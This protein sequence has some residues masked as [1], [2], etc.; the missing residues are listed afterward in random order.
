MDINFICG[1]PRAGTTFL[2]NL[3][4]KHSRIGSVG[5]TLYFGR[6]FIESEND[7]YND[8]QINKIQ[9][10]LININYKNLKEDENK[11]FQENIVAEFKKI[12]R[13][14]ASPKVVFNAYAKAY[15]DVFEG[16]KIFFEKTPHHIQH[17]ERIRM[18]YP[19]AKF[20]ILMRD[21]Y[22]WML[23][24]K[25]QGSQVNKVIR[26]AFKSI[27]HP[28]ACALIWK[29][30]YNSIEKVK[31]QIPNQALI[32]DNKN[33]SDKKTLMEIFAFLNVEFEDIKHKKMNSSFET[34]DKQALTPIDIYWMNLI[35]SKLIRTSNFTIKKVKVSLKD[36]VRSLFKV[37]PLIIN[38]STKIKVNGS[39]VNY[40]L[41][42]LKK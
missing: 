30:N 5:E 14:T 38:V 26:D 20:L 29:K 1:M 23:S 10:R 42:Y 9:K 16:K 3:I 8:E 12:K 22:E 33:L 17:I 4:N 28:I 31:K 36:K 41:K 6:M 11:I 2:S 25:Y 39:K 18:Y 34:I 13:Q 37:I 21:P 7:T 40:F 32:L 15:L 27:Y 35:N 24:Y 19:N